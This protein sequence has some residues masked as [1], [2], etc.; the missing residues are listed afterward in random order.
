MKS[1]IKGSILLLEYLLFIFSAIFLFFLLIS[2]GYGVNLPGFWDQIYSYLPFLMASICIIRTLL[3]IR[4]GV[5][6]IVGAF[7]QLFILILVDHPNF[8][9]IFFVFC[10]AI[11][12]YRRF[13]G[14]PIIKYLSIKFALNPSL[15]I[16][17]SFLVVIILGTLLLSLPAASSN[18]VSVGFL[19]A[20]FTATS[21]VCVTGLIVVNTPV[22]F[23]LFGKIVIMILFQVGGL[24][25]MTMSTF[26]ISFLKQSLSGVHVYTMQEQF[27]K[28]GERE[29]KQMLTNIFMFTAI[30]ELLGFIFLYLRFISDMSYQDAILFAAFHAIS[31]FCNAGFSLFEDSLMGYRSDVTINIVICT[32]IVLGG[33]GFIVLRDLAQF[34]LSDK[35]N[36][37]HLKLNTKLVLTTTA[38]LIISG[39]LAIL[40][41]DFNKALSGM[42]PLTRLLAALFQSITARTA[43]FNTLNIAKMSR[44]SIV[45]LMALMVVGGSSGSTAGGIKTN[46]LAVLVLTIRSFISR[47]KYVSGFNREISSETISRAISVAVLSI[48]VI[49]SGFLILLHTQKGSFEEIL[50]E[51]ISAFGTVGLSM[52]LTDHLNSIGKIVVILLMFTG[53]IGP[54]TVA[55]S[56]RGGK[57]KKGFRQP[58]EEVQVG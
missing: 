45:V 21:A 37:R 2:S 6:W 9:G 23:S 14:S 51:T 10:A 53:R 52:G 42:D 44:A 31:A 30:V 24:G 26:L 16:L 48:V 54:L 34:F 49:M 20:L 3:H 50:F 18:G 58:E 25:I 22:A 28:S 36:K 11:F 4:R 39:T 55:V 13:S 33:L 46:T 19:N 43:G 7:I 47:K 40:F 41:F 56:L 27:T 17:L 57:L 32:L 38:T 5:L 8:V 12:L 15:G 29:I 35:R 1:S